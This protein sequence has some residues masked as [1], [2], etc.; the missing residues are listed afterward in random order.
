MSDH[1]DHYRKDMNRSIFSNDKRKRSNS[2]HDNHER[3]KEHHEEGTYK[4]ARGVEDDEEE[5]ARYSRDMKSYRKRLKEQWGDRIRRDRDREKY[6]QRDRDRRGDRSPEERPKRAKRKEHLYSSSDEEDEETDEGNSRSRHRGSSG[7]YAKD[8]ATRRVERERDRYEG[9]DSLRERRRSRKRST[10]DDRSDDGSSDRRKERKNFRRRHSSERSSFSEKNSMKKKKKKKKSYSSSDEESSNTDKEVNKRR[11]GN[12]KKREKNEEGGDGERSKREDKN[13]AP[14][15][16]ATNVVGGGGEENHEDEN[17]LSR[18]ERLKRFAQKIMNRGNDEGSGEAGTKIN[19]KVEREIGTKGTKFTL[20]KVISSAG[21]KFDLDAFGGGRQDEEDGDDEEEGK[22]KLTKREQKNCD[23]RQGLGRGDLLSNWP[24]EE[25]AVGDDNEDPL[26]VFMRN[27]E[28]NCGEEEGE[29]VG[30]NQAI[31]LEEIYRYDENRHRFE[32]AKQTEEEDPVEA[33]HSGEVAKETNQRDMQAPQRADL[34]EDEDGEEYHRLFIEALRKKGEEEGNGNEALAPHD[35]GICAGSGAGSGAG[36][37]AGSSEAIENLSEDSEYNIETNVLKKTNKKFLQVN[38]EEVEYLPI[39]KNI[40][41]QVSEITNMKDSDVDLFRKNNGNIIV[42]GKNCPRPVQYFY[43][44]GLPS[45]ILPILE[46]KNFKK[47]FGI[48]MQTIPAL[49]CGRDVIAIAETGSGKTLSYLFPLIRHVLHQAPLRNN[50]GPIAIILTPTRE[51]SKQVKSEARPYCQ[52]VNLR[53]LAVYGGSNI[54]TQ[55]NTLKRGVEILVG[56][57]GRIIDILTI[58]NCKVTNLNRVSFVVLDEADRLLDLGFESQ[59]HNILNNCR[60]DKQTAMISATFPSYI[61]NLAKKLLYK[62]IEIIVGEKG[63]TNNNIYQFVEVLQVKEK[64]FRLLKL[65]GDWSTYGLILIFVNK[66]LEADLLYLELFKYD[67]KTLV[68][69][70]GQDQADREFTLQTFKEGKNKILIATSVMARGIDIKD[71]IVVINYECPDHIED[72]IHRVG[73]T[74]RSN[75]I[76]YAYTFVS[77]DEH[78]KAYDIYSLIKNNIYYM[79]KTIDIPRQ[80]EELVLEYTQS[81]NFAEVKKKGYKGKGF[82]FTPNEKSRL[83]MDKA[84]AK[85]ELGLVRDKEGAAENPAEGDAP[86][87]EMQGSFDGAAASRMGGN[88]PP[89]VTPQSQPQ[90]A[91]PQPPPPPP[92]PGEPSP[93]SEIKRIELEIQR[94][95]MND[96]MDLSLKAKQINELMKTYNFV[97][98]QQSTLKKNADSTEDTDIEKMAEQ[99]ATKATEHIKNETER[100]QLFNKIKQDVKKKLMDSKMQSNSKAENIHRSMLLNSM[101]TRNMKK[102][103][104]FIPHTYIMEDNSIMQEFYINDYPQH[105]RLRICNREVLSR[106][107]DMSGSRC[108]IKGQYSNPNQPNKTTFLLDAKPLHIEITA[109][110]YNQVQIAHNEFTSMINQLLQ[111]SNM[112]GH[113]KG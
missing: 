96:T 54:G 10:S 66:Q 99:E 50:D 35:A 42:R 74:G 75:K 68:L 80:L 109:S 31:T 20:N 40:Y 107:S 57:P 17:K 85:R 105:V 89:M 91:Q 41:V 111:N 106:I 46:K 24:E 104:P 7:R 87:G 59:I 16:T 95:K 2:R 32:G 78:A 28:Q 92:P 21:R 19:A 73:R 77:P 79:N 63:K 14:I 52:A 23:T 38:R 11:E 34:E 65:L 5:E 1:Y 62:P 113:R 18:L 26:E 37:S 12:K 93:Q 102:Y 81:S 13:G 67:Y 83:Q 72:Y 49:M 108:Q 29:A 30:P 39:K 60:K 33:V 112:K 8:A 94:I 84:N 48:Q 86:D 47:M 27:L 64:I 110:N 4:R 103:S 90:Q 45:K 71:I 15:V 36:S 56:T 82:K 9:K 43:Q 76:G 58:S 97:A 25:P 61:Q 3:K 69:H 44:C 22:K 98:L 53:I 51:L 101:R 100:K 6:Y 88:A 70:G 55:L